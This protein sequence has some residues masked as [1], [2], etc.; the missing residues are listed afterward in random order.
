MDGASIACAP[1]TD[2][3]G[4]SLHEF[5]TNPSEPLATW[6]KAYPSTL[7]APPPAE[8]PEAA[9]S[10]LARRPG[11]GGFR[12]TG[13]VVETY[14]PSPCP[15]NAKCKPTAPRHVVLGG[16]LDADAAAPKLTLLTPEARSLAHNTRYEV[17]LVLCDAGYGDGVLVNFRPLAPS[18]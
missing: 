12:T 16:A 5:I 4:A 1:F 2:V 11:S 17:A 10:E 7:D 8:W 3:M 18:P 14:V 9:F 13:W 15:P 6:P